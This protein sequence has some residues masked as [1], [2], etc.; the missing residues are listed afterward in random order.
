MASIHK[1]THDALISALSE[2][3]VDNY[4]MR[5]PVVDEPEK[6]RNE[7]LK[8]F[9]TDEVILDIFKNILYPPSKKTTKKKTKKV[10]PKVS[11][12]DRQ[13][14]EIDTERCLC[15][16]WKDGLD[17]VQCSRKKKVGDF[18]TSHSKA[19]AN[20]WCGLITEPRPEEP[21]LPNKKDPNLPP[22]RHYWK[23]QEQPAKRSKNKKKVK[24]ASGSDAFSQP[25]P[26]KTLNIV[27]SDDD[28]SDQSPNTV[29]SPTPSTASTQMNEDDYDYGSSPRDED[30]EEIE[31]IDEHDDAEE[32]E[33]IEESDEADAIEEIEDIEEIDEVPSD[34]DECL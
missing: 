18:C 11:I 12:I 31:E 34:D 14:A 9:Q 13:S 6:E 3:V 1:L 21:M 32:I 26:P 16:L 4:V 8:L 20:W 29:S 22:N 17:N 25:P 15:R 10:S 2:H 19:G 27:E 24:E 5:C 7:M 33:E 30:A 23:D 28:H